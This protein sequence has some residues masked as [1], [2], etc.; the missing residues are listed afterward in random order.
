MTEGPTLGGPPA[1]AGGL[2]SSATPSKA[3]RTK[4]VAKD[5]LDELANALEAGNSEQLD[6]FLAAMAR[7]HA[8]SSRNILLILSQKPDATRVAGFR[9]WQTL[10]RQVKKG[11]KGIAILAPMLVRKTGHAKET[12]DG[13]DPERILR[14]RVVHVFD[15]SQTEGE[16][17][18]EPERVS[19]DPREHL[20][21]LETFVVQAGIE[22]EYADDLGSAEGTSSGGMI[23]IKRGLPPAERF[24]VLVHE[25]AHEILHQGEGVERPDKTV[26]ETEAE[27]VAHVVGRAIGL[28]TRTSSSDYIRLYR[29]DSRTL[30]DSLDRIQRAACSIIEGIGPGDR[31]SIE[32]NAAPSIARATIESRQ[33]TR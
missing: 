12:D 19:G 27:A 28:E 30:A 32:S 24:S 3:E 25:M 13:D 21:R 17:L 23:R 20:N 26:R 33:R 14:F 16:P 22:L 4:Q 6:A 2:A 8:Y 10:G 29:G 15:M 7:F 5:A 1:Q 31:S 11:E 9:T 18:P